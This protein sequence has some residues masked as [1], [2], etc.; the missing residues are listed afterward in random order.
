MV[1]G[2][3]PDQLQRQCVHLAGLH[4]LSDHRRPAGNE[5]H[6]LQP[7]VARPLAGV[8]WHELN[9]RFKRDYAAAVESV[10]QEIERRGGDRKAIEREVEAIYRQ[11]ADLGLERGPRLAPRK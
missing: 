10:L 9:E 7:V 6:L 4:R 11:L 5:P 2:R 8:P 1:G 3:A